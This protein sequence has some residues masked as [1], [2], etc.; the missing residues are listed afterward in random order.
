MYGDRLHTPK[1]PVCIVHHFVPKKVKSFINHV[2]ISQPFLK[3]VDN[4]YLLKKLFKELKKIKY[5]GWVSIEMKKQD[6]NN[7]KKIF[8]SIKK[9]KKFAA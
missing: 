5:N 3:P 4:E 8:N 7:Y 6:F 2:H 9:V 1:H